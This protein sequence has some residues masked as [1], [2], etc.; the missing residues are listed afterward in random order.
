MKKLL[1]LLLGIGLS[2]QFAFGAIAFD[3]FTNG[4]HTTATN[5]L[6]WT[7]TVT[8]SNA[9]LVVC[10][11][12]NSADAPVSATYNGV[13]MTLV[14]SSDG[15]IGFYMLKNPATGANTVTVTH[16]GSGADIAGISM[17]YTGVDQTTNPEANALASNG[18]GSLASAVTTLT[19]NAWVT[20]CARSEDSSVSAGANTILR[21]TGVS[22]VSYKLYGFDS[23]GAVT[24]AG[25]RT[26]NMTTTGGGF[27]NDFFVGALKPYTASAASTKGRFMGF[28]KF[29]R[30]R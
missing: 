30:F 10:E 6:S 2:T 27:N 25:S 17:S 14:N 12:M 9:I 1:V 16:T 3:T 29:F 11:F 15:R 4:G 21:G 23:N 5:E 26:L 13:A 20:G 19:D 28:F 7:H 8:G 18:G 22:G 24:P